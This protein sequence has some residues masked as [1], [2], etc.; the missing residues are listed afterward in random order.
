MQGPQQDRIS[1]RQLEYFVAVAEALSFRR[2]AERLGVSQ[3]TLTGQIAA[4][5]GALDV[6]LLERSRAGTMLSPAG[7]ELLGSAQAVLEQARGL[8]DRARSLAGG[9]TGTFRLGVSPTLGPYL[10][11][12]IL[13]DLHRAYAGVKL[14]VREAVPRTLLEELRS[15]RYDLILTALPIPDQQLTVAPLFQEPIK[16]VLGPD[17]RLASRDLIRPEDLRGVDVLLIDEAHLFH[18]QIE[19]LCQ[20]LGANVRRDYEGTSLDT[21]RHMVLMGMGV[22]VPAR[23]CTCARRSARRTSC[24]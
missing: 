17:H 9:P 19:Q 21:L 11:P 16:L 15:G 8:T 24:G 20:R 6:V 22:G 2:A 14:Y 12:H 5:E 18:R 3:P 10:L 13:P 4:L 1:L 7:R 23:R